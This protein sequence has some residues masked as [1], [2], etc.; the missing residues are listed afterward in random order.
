VEKLRID[1]KNLKDLSRDPK[2]VNKGNNYVL[3]HLGNDTNGAT[4]IF[5]EKVTR[6]PKYLMEPVEQNKTANKVTKFTFMGNNIEVVANYGLAFYK[7]PALIL[8]EGITYSFGMA[9]ALNDSY[10]AI[11]PN[12][13]YSVDHFAFYHSY[14]LEKIVY[15][16]TVYS[17]YEYSYHLNYNLKTLVIPHI[18]NPTAYHNLFDSKYPI[19]VYGDD[20]T[21]TWVNNVIEKYSYDIVYKP[22]SEYQSSITSEIGVSGSA[23]YNDSFTFESNEEVKAYYTYTNNAGTNFILDEVK[24]DKEGNKYTIN[25]I[26]QDIII[27]KSV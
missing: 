19:T 3:Y 6:I 17:I 16:P 8:P 1:S 4:I 25:N 11:L 14:N 26:K 20:S 12:T 9:F 21:Q 2:D 24:M 5:G 27:K 22:L 10:L 18:D 13:L 23:G 15:G 7:G